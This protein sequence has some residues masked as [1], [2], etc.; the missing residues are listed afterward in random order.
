MDTL[1]LLLLPKWLIPIE[2]KNTVMEDMGIA[3]HQGRIHAMDSPQRLRSRYQFL[4]QVELGSHVVLPGFVNAHSHAAMSL[5]R[6]IADDTPLEPWLTDH[7]WPLEQQ[8]MSPEYVEDGVRLALLEM[9]LGGTTCVQDMY[10]F[11]DVVARTGADVGMR[12]GV[13]AVVIDFPS[14]WGES[15]DD[16]VRK[17]LQLHD[18]YKGHPLISVAFAPHATYTVSP[19]VLS[20]L[21]VLSEQL[22][23]GIQIHLQESAQEVKDVCKMHGQ[24]P[25][26]LLRSLGLLTPTLTAIHMTQV[27]DEE[28]QWL[29]ISNCHVVHCPESNLKLASGLCPVKKLL[30]AGINVGLGTDSAASNNNLSML[31]EM[32]TAA[33]LGKGV[34]QD[35]TAISAHEALHMATLGSAHT[36]GLGQ[37]IGSLEIGKWADV[38]AV[39]MNNI[40]LQP[41]YDPASQLVYAAA[42]QHVSDVWI[43][44]RRMV[45]SGQPT[46]IDTQE[47]LRKT[48]IWQQRFSNS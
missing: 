2:P 16:Y 46:G 35:A 25:M 37:E 10:F 7:I 9:L 21:G 18:A 29:S 43:A 12:M 47:V 38:T 8:W 48:Q 42:D 4:E 17:A 45:E 30:S 40:P 32:Q 19:E 14:A 31:G 5:M 23:M 34:A 13:G 44:G 33:L 6:G 15:A 11:P 39:D 28:I 24:R 36:M 41:V 20:K 27:T 3:I 1:D 26:A 22:D